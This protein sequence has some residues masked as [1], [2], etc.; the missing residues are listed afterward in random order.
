MTLKTLNP[1]KLSPF[2]FA[3]SAGCCTAGFLL[4]LLFC[5][6]FIKP[7]T[8]QTEIPKREMRASW[9]TTVWGLDWPGIKIPAGGSAV[10]VTMQKQQLTRIL[11]SMQVTGMNAVFFQVRPECDAFY[12][13]S[14]EPWS[15]HL[16]ASRGQDPGWD[17]LQYAVEEAHKRGLELHAW[18]NPYRFESVAGKYSGQPGDY[19]QTHPEWVL[20]YSGGG[21]IL[22]PGNPGVRQL[23]ADIVT[24]IVSRYDVDGVVFDDYFYAYGGTSASLDQYSQERWRPAGMDLGDWR[25]DN[26]NRMVAGV[27]QAIQEVKPWVTFGVSPFGIWTTD[28]MV[29]ASRGLTLPSGITGSD[30]YK[31]IYCDPVAW[32]EAK[33]VDYISPQLYWPTTSSGQSYKILAPWWSEVVNRFGRHLYVSHSL[34]DLDPSD[35]P[36]PLAMDPAHGEFR[37]EEMEGLSMIEYFSKREILKS[38]AGYDPSEFGLQV[39]W[40]RRSDKNDAPGSVFFRSTNFF[41]KGIINYFRTHEFRNKALL[42]VKHWN[43]WTP[44]PVPANLR[45]EGSRLVWD[46]AGEN[47]RYAVYAI[48][49]EIAGEPGNFNSGEY[50]L[51]ISWQPAFDLTNYNRYLDSHLFAVS[52]LDRNG[53][54]SAPALMNDIPR[55]NRATR[56]VF[57]VDG[58][59]LYPGFQFSWEAVPLADSYL[60]E[61]A[62]DSSFTAIAG[63][64]EVTGSTF[65]SGLLGLPE[66]RD[67]YWRVYTRMAG[68]KD[69]VSEKNSFRLVEMPRVRVT[70]PL[71]EASGVEVTPLIRWESLGEG[72]SYRL[73]IS[74]VNTF[75]TLLDDRMGIEGTDFRL[76]AG[77]ISSYGTYY[78]RMLGTKGDS[79]TLWSDVVRFATVRIPPAIPEIINPINGAQILGESAHV[80]VKADLLASG[81]TFQW[82]TLSSFPWN[83]RSQ[84]SV[85]APDSS[86]VLPNLASGTWYVRCRATYSSSLYTEWSP[87]VSFSFL[88]SGIS[89]ADNPAMALQCSGLVGR[90]PLKITFSLPGRGRMKL[91]L[92]DMTGRIRAVLR[93]GVPVRGV[94]EA[95]I[96][97]EKIPRG[98]HLVVLESDYGRK[99][100]KIVRP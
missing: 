36:P 16:V 33:T 70:Y 90:E 12:P 7:T 17:P 99:A 20:T 28:P 68:V 51:G 66:N 49:E 18:L 38:T 94:H 67:Y 13:S 44:L 65:P 60:L 21:T 35:Y 83:N 91:F 34:S 1:L 25:R 14:F 41:T 32:L 26:V 55:Q 19:R 47:L 69:T 57:P 8:G 50:L 9:L 80:I 86:L 29:A 76:P 87:V 85:D 15:A 77:V 40:N 62:E 61:V 59:N 6:F 2:H 23:I 54:E 82:S 74:T 46:A 75:S 73:Q 4:T 84:Q 5:A 48:P 39:E 30:M 31:S 24:E 81:F 3:A 58:V 89:M 53:N 100:V 42:P 11:D 52:I 63:R 64:R 88:L 22:D 78:L 71:N 43:P 95:V 98:I 27:Y 79:V 72:Y 56:L 93:E 45:M 10:N 97:A 92:T 37:Y 96:P